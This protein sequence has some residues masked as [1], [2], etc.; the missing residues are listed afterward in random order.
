[1]ILSMFPSHKTFRGGGSSI[2]KEVRIGHLSLLPH[3]SF[4]FGVHWLLCRPQ[5]ETVL[6]WWGLTFI[7]ISSRQYM[8]TSHARLHNSQHQY[9]EHLK[10]SW[11]AWNIF[12]G[13]Y[14]FFIGLTLAWHQFRPENNQWLPRL[15][16]PEWQDRGR[17]N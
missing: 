15:S 13:L 12:P 4:S 10:S 17:I 7:T 14:F 11:Q 16:D 5:F 2:S 9:V 1:M 3:F 6:I 8:A